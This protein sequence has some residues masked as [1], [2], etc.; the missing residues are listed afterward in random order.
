MDSFTQRRS[1]LGLGA[2]GAVL[3]TGALLDPHK[4]AAQAGAN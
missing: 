4:A 2:A 3:A 1:V